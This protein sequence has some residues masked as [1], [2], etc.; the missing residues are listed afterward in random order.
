MKSNRTGMSFFLSEE[1]NNIKEKIEFFENLVFNY[2]DFVR[3]IEGKD[4]DGYII[5]F[6]EKDST[7][8]HCFDDNNRITAKLLTLIDSDM[9]KVISKEYASKE[10]VKS[11]LNDMRKK[12]YVIE[13]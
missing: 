5:I 13:F 6:K 4:Y 11:A 3:T 10:E 8:Y 12:N 2:I 1:E 9:I 7:E